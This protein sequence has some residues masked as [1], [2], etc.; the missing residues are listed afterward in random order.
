MKSAINNFG[1][2]NGKKVDQYVLENDLGMVVRIINYG[3][4]IT[5][6]TVPD[7]ESRHVDLVC[8]FDTM[9]GYL[10]TVY[11]QNAPYF[12]C[13]VGR[14]ASR[15]KDGSFSVN[16]KKYQVACN[17][18]S[19]HLH[20][21]IVGFNK[22]LWEADLLD[23]GDRVGVKMSLVS[24]H[25]EEGHPGNLV[26]SAVFSSDNNNTLIISYAAKTDEETPVSLTNH[27]YFNL[28]GFKN[29]ILE[30]KA[31]VLASSHLKPDET[32]VPVGEVELLEGTP[33]DLNKEVYLK[34][35]LRSLE[36]GFEHYFLFDKDPWSL[37]KVA[38]FTDGQS[39]GNWK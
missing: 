32:N 33:A 39:I 20:G 1:S 7:I 12:G 8:G 28:S 5:S 19:N 2:H 3:A 31:I 23:D 21:G 34:D 27:S 30:H 37:A 35:A 9:E 29:N 26:V 36:T 22:R 18:G 24:P 13:T 15:I 11:Q 17:D 14:Y 38:E 16:G 6:I 4:T 10:S 25:L